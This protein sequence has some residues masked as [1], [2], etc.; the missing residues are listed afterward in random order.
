[1]QWIIKTGRLPVSASLWEQRGFFNEILRLE[2][3]G[4][5]GSLAVLMDISPLRSSI[6]PSIYR[7]ATPQGAVIVTQTIMKHSE[8]E[9]RRKQ[10]LFSALP[11]IWSIHC[12]L[13]QRNVLQISRWL[14]ETILT[15]R[16]TSVAESCPLLT[17]IT[18][19]VTSNVQSTSKVKNSLAPSPPAQSRSMKSSALCL[20]WSDMT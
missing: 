19:C 20:M 1:M 9:M 10:R 4:G 6:Y 7:A 16:T 15:A 13:K 14:R 17:L 8:E 12:T 3:E 5:G 18:L 11:F 2:A